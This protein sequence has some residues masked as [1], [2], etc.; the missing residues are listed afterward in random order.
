MSLYDRLMESDQG[1]LAEGVKVGDYVQARDGRSGYADRIEA[2]MVYFKH[3]TYKSSENVVLPIE[4][5]NVSQVEDENLDEAS[6]MRKAMKRGD[7][8]VSRGWPLD[9][10]D[11][12]M[13]V[14]LTPR[15]NEMLTGLSKKNQWL[16]KGTHQG[17]RAERETAMDRVAHY[18][19]GK[20][21]GRHAQPPTQ[22]G[23][24]RDADEVAAYRKRMKK[25]KAAR[26]KKKRRG[27]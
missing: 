9:P 19:Q 26:G 24:G 20:V 2:G 10:G 13:I 1:P 4:E 16:K 5:V 3:M 14:A 25:H 7:I 17:R 18:S 15:G 8:K 6:R 12:G 21:H 22:G 11:K 27:R 23:F